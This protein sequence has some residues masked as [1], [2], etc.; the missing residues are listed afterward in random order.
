MKSSK[1]MSE[2]LILGMLLAVC[3][4]FLDAYTYIM[5]GG[6]FANAQT[7]NIVLLG[8]SIAKGD[9]SKAVY[10]IFPIIAFAIGIL[11]TEIVRSRLHSSSILHWRQ[12]IVLS[13]IALLFCTAFVP[14]G[15]A[16]IVVNTTVS[17]VCSLQVEGFRV[18]SGNKVATTMC[19]G[20]LRSATEL[21]FYGVKTG[22]K[23][24]IKDSLTYYS[25]NLFFVLGAIAGAWLT[26]FFGLKSVWF[27]CLLL[28]VPFIM[29][30]RVIKGN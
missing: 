24:K 2:N 28:I 5:R 6:V 25:I 26:S 19:T 14:E 27:V 29:M 15:R 30:F 23:A 12:I 20:N 8:I 3:G 9:A 18:I 11:I 17:F 21:L 4:G 10:Y 22:N 1:Q 13:E 7:G 16:D